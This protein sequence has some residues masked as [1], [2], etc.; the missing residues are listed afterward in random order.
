[1]LGV[2]VDDASGVTREEAPVAAVAAVAAVAVGVLTATAA[3]SHAVAQRLLL[4]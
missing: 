4:L 2:V 3:V 1:M